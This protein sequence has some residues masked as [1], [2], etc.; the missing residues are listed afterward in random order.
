MGG[1]S[2]YIEE[3]GLATTQISLIR[4]HTEITRPPRALWVPFEMGRPFGVPNNEKFQTKVL[5]A[6]L[7]LLEAG[8]GPL[9]VDFPEDA[10]ASEAPSI[11][12]A[13]PVSF[14]S[15]ED[16]RSLT[17]M[18]L[19]DFRDEISQMSS[20][21]GI[22]LTN[23]GRTTAGLSGLAPTNIAE[24][25]AAFIMGQREASPILD[26]SISTALRMTVEDLK[27]FYFEAVVAQP[28]HVSDSEAVADWFWS[29]TTAA[30][31]INAIRE[32]CLGLKGNDYQLLGKLLLIP[33]SQ[34]HRFI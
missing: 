4:E 20:W 29:Q 32:I 26:V 14:A 6:V 18:M 9:L 16:G 8:E 27:A 23:S 12:L 34:L 11:L 30:R 33:R 22:S 5:V 17:S 7:G 31:V 21:Y 25:L 28:G 1:L 2:H 13:C 15:R 24:F 10:P 3:E 19:N